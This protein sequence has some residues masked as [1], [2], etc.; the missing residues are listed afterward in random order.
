MFAILR[1]LTR[2][3][4]D[5]WVLQF[6]LEFF[7]L[8]FFLQRPSQSRAYTFFLKQQ[9]QPERQISDWATHGAKR[10]PIPAE[11]EFSPSRVPSESSRERTDQ[12][13]QSKIN[14]EKIFCITDSQSPP[15]PFSSLALSNRIHRNQLLILPPLLIIQSI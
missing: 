11:S 14:E 1:F 15:L 8:R 7:P 5:D 3:F 13:S 6:P 10:C 12:F 4:F 9:C 2:L